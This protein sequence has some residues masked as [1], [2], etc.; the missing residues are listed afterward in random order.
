M[1]YQAD[2]ARLNGVAAELRAALSAGH[3][4]I[5]Q[6]CPPKGKAVSEKL[7][8][9]TCISNPHGWQSRLRLA[10]DAIESWRSQGAE[11][12]L[13]E[14]AYGSRG[15]D[16]DDIHGITHVP[17]RATTL[18]WNKENLINIGIG[19][20]PP[21]ARKIA[22]I[23]ADVI[24]R[25]DSWVA[26]AIRALDIYHVIQPWSVCYDLGPNAEH[27][28]VHKSFAFQHFFGHPLVPAGNKFWQGDG[29]PYDYPHSGYAWAYTRDFLDRIGGMIDWAGMGSA[30]HHMAL[31][32]VGKIEASAPAGTSHHYREH[33]TKWQD[34]AQLHLNG[35]LGYL[36]LTIEHAWHGAKVK[37][38]YVD[39]WGMFVKHNFDPHTDLKKNSY[40]VLEFAGNKPDLERDF[41]RYLRERDEDSNSL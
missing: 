21:S 29:G 41:D 24:W 7:H 2:I 25:N 28:A 34:R 11:V 40:G 8:V 5:G 18:A 4:T 22:C 17:V 36:P 3:R 14:C 26:Q 12:T 38:R 39:R 10:R 20:L 1:S 16:L 13:V 9:V 33:L 6:S 35:K 15:H 23:D 27:M 30:D 19:R 31:G 37:R 32:L